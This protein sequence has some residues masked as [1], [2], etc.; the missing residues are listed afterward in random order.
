MTDKSE[1]QLVISAIGQDRKGLV[2]QLS[3]AIV[4]NGANILDSRMT[5]LGGEFA[6][7]ILV[8]AAWN[9]L[10]KLEQQ[11]PS[12]GQ[13]LG[14][15][16]ISKRT[17][18]TLHT[19]AAIPYHVEVVAIDQPGIVKQIAG[20]FSDQGINIYDLNTVGYQAAHTGTPLFSI[21]MTIN[22]PAELSLSELR[23]RF[24][25]LCDQQ[26]IDGIIEPIK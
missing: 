8:T 11:L 16:L 5:I 10:A 19:E 4:D 6:I 13:E 12:L 24:F 9:S 26:N 2:S 23:E 22:V 3:S 17:T 25:S 21:S 7:L 14:L 20:F 18:A 1:Q 15:T